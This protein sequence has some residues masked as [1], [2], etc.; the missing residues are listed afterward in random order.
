MAGVLAVVVAIAFIQ[1]YIQNEMTKRQ[2]DF[3]SDT[4]FANMPAYLSSLTP[5]MGDVLP[6]IRL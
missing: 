6:Q 4:G 1:P 3:L 2:L 5:P